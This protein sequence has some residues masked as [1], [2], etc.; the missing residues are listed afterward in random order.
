MYTSQFCWLSLNVVQDTSLDSSVEWNQFLNQVHA[1]YLATYL[2]TDRPR[3]HRQTATLLL[4]ESLPKIESAI[5][6]TALLFRNSKSPLF[7]LVLL[8]RGAYRTLQNLASSASRGKSYVTT[9]AS[10]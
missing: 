1:P 10:R 2:P 3:L 7:Q 6:T 9:V 4:F 5:T 8:G